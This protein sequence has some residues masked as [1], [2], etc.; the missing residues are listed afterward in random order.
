M[1]NLRFNQ[2]VFQVLLHHHPLVLSLWFVLHL[3]QVFNLAQ[4]QVVNQLPNQVVCLLFI[5]H[6]SL[7]NNRQFN[8]LVN[9]AFIH[10]RLHLV[11]PVFSRVVNLF[12]VQL[13]NQRYSQ[14][15][16]PALS[17]RDIHLLFQAVHHRFNP[18]VNHHDH[19]RIN[20]VV[21]LHVYLRLN[22]QCIPV[23]SLLINR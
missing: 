7:P 17:H 16:N 3:N 20:L 2:V 15:G 21:N 14:V 4:F 22:L 11:H 9:L 6:L 8:L 5:L 19:L 18:A 13:I 10:L 23:D 12:V 1:F